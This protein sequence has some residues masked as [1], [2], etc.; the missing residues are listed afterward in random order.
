VLQDP[1]CNGAYS[2]ALEHLKQSSTSAVEYFDRQ[3]P[4]GVPL[5]IVVEWWPNGDLEIEIADIGK[6]RVTLRD[7]VNR[8]QIRVWSGGLDVEDLDYQN[9]RSS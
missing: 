1:G 5:K 7:P 2:F 9:L 4:W 8:I 3:L 6:R